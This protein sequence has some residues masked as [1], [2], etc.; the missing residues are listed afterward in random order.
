MT[1]LSLWASGTTSASAPTIGGART[2]QQLTD[3]IGRWT[4]H[5]DDHGFGATLFQDRTTSQLVGWGGLQHATIGIG[6]CLTVGYVIT[7]N[8]WGHGYTTEIAGAAVAHAF[9]V[10]GADRLY[11]SVLA[12]NTAS[13]RVL[14]KVGLSMHQ[15]IDH[16]DHIEVIYAIAR[17]AEG[18]WKRPLLSG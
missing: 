2:E 14:E 9:S 11:A 4:R 16:G 12:T 6:A 8:A 5:W 17:G 1:F 10:L 13:R 7:P 15:E 3:R 18:M